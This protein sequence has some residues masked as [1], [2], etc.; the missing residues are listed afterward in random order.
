MMSSR[1]LA[2]TVV[3]GKL[4]TFR[5]SSG[6]DLVGYLAG[7][8]DFHWLVLTSEGCMVL[9]HKGSASRI[10][11]AAE[12]TYDDEE[13]LSLLEQVVRPFREYLVQENLVPAHSVRP[14]ASR[15]T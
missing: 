5:F 6:E 10:S 14:N 2:R 7:M 9:V 3:D 15:G 4:L 8:D 1:Q 13:R 11:V 12:S